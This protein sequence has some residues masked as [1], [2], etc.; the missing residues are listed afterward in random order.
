MKGKP[1]AQKVQVLLV[2]D[3]QGGEA[4][5]TVMFALD[6][7]AYEIDLNNENADRL[8]ELLAPYVDKGRKQ[9]G[10]LSSR[11]GRG[12]GAARSTA[13]AAQD[14]AR[15]RSW[16]KEHGFAVSDRGRVPS[17]VREAYEKAHA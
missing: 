14:T 1:V 13:A 12:R 11:S 15:I 16:A 3:L 7:V 4:D 6:G 5:E 17:N 8:R 2:D 10:K 9:S